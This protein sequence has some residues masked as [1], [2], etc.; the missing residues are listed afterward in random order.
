MGVKSFDSDCDKKRLC[1]GLRA[2]RRVAP[3]GKHEKRTYE[4]KRR[5]HEKVKQKLKVKR[6]IFSF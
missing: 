1:K 2:S 4:K 5:K 3:V 6:I